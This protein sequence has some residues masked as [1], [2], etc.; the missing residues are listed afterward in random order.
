M[1]HFTKKIYIPELGITI[2]PQLD[3]VLERP[4]SSFI[5]HEP[6]YF[7]HRIVKR[8][9][10]E[11]YN[12]ETDARKA[13]NACITLFHVTDWFCKSKEEKEEIFK[14]MPYNEAL[15]SIANGTKHFNVNKP[16]KT[17]RKEGTDKPTKLL[18][19]KDNSQIELTAMLKEIEKF[20]DEKLGEKY[21]AVYNEET[22]TFE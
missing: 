12:D 2:E 13:I 3:I 20:W 9:L 15:E 16:Y 8:N 18:V 1:A 7:Y 5:Y 10:Q 6:K 21:L 17:G 4:G 19:I 22:Q 11:F 14:E